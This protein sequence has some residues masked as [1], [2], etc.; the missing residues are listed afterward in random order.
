MYFDTKNTLKNNHNHTPKKTIYSD[1]LVVLEAKQSYN[2]M[3]CVC[4]GC[5]MTTVFTIFSCVIFI[6]IP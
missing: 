5:G 4:L 2:G 3:T 6:F 1:S